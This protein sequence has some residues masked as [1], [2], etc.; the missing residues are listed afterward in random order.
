MS[1]AGLLQ[2]LQQG[3]A[4]NTAALWRD[5]RAKADKLRLEAA[6]EI[7]AE[8]LA[9]AQ[10]VAATTQRIEQAETA[11]A[12]REARDIRMRAAIALAER[13]H[14]LALAELPNLRAQ[15]PESL[16][17]ALAAELP[18]VAWQKVKVNPGDETLA[19]QHFPQAH[20]ECDPRISGGM[21][22]EAE[23][24]RIRVNNTLEARLEAAWPE[25]LSGLIATILREASGHES[26]ARH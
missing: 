12:E 9:S 2:R 25:L 16:F 1:R 11:A 23:D 20:L 5:A 14:G 8:R 18:V 22:T 6:R 26:P 21:A 4:E 13:L 24:G 3:A 10:Q 17:S 7:D 15:N 19:R